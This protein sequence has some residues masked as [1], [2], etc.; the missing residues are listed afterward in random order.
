MDNG[1]A[2]SEYAETLEAQKSKRWKVLLDVQ[3]PYRWNLKRLKPGITLDVG[4]GIG[5]NLVNLP[6]GSVGVDINKHSVAKARALGYEAHTIES[7]L[8]DEKHGSED[9]RFDSL[10][11]S[12]VL[13]HLTLDQSHELLKTYLRDGGRVI[14]ICPREGC[15]TPQKGHARGEQHITFLDAQAME[16]LLKSQNLETERA[17]SFPFPRPVGKVFK[18]NETV[19]VARK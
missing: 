16:S 15:A 12:H 6:Q 17:Y 10:L 8:S 19:V 14:A 18:Y 2:E 3:R 5:R 1:A 7:F 11:I 13:E 9:P 4:C